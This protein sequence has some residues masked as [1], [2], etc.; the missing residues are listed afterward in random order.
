MSEE[1]VAYFC[2][3]SVRFRKTLVLFR[4]GKNEKQAAGRFA[5]KAGQD[6]R[7]Q[8]EKIM[9]CRGSDALEGWRV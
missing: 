9:D 5:L 3:E 7:K 8:E 2:R 6:G 1:E 4:L